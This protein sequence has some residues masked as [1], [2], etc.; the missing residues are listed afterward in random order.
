MRSPIPRCDDV[1]FSF[2]ASVIEALERSLEDGEFIAFF[3]CDFRS[4]RST[5]AAQVM[6]SLL[7]QLIHRFRDGTVEPGDVLYDLIKERRRSGS[8][9]NNAKRLA[10]LV[11]SAAKQFIRKPLIVIDALDEC[12]DIQNLLDALVVLSQARLR[13]FATSRPLQL[14][15]DQFVGL[16]SLSLEKMSAAVSADIQLHVIRELD[17]DRR[18]R[19]APARLKEQIRYTLCENAD[20]M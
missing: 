11:S 4:E 2:S 5:D 17:S 20:G 13:L 16:P 6:R 8:I 18:L 7:S 9:L 15:K 10:R 1:D 3:Y 19:I 12:K 14:I